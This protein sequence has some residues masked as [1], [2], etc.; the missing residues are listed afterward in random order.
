MRKD[1]RA[2]RPSAI[3]RRRWR[4]KRSVVVGA[5]IACLLFALALLV[6][7]GGD[8]TT[9]AL[10]VGKQQ[11]D[12]E[13]R[14]AGTAVP[15][16]TTTAT[17]PLPTSSPPSPAATHKPVQHF[18][19]PPQGEAPGGES[20]EENAGKEGYKENVRDPD[21]G[22]AD[23]DDDDPAV[24]QQEKRNGFDDNN[25]PGGI[26]Q[27]KET[28]H[29]PGE[30][31]V[32]PPD[33]DADSIEEATAPPR[34][35]PG[36]KESPAA[37]KNDRNRGPAAGP[38]G[39][40]HK[41]NT[42][43]DEED[44]VGNGGGGGGG[45]EGVGDSKPTAAPQDDEIETDVG[46]GE[47]DL[48][49]RKHFGRWAREG[50]ASSAVEDDDD[51]NLGR[52]SSSIFSKLFEVVTR[53]QIEVTRK[54]RVLPILTQPRAPLGRS[55]DWLP[56]VPLSEK[57][58]LTIAKEG[59]TANCIRNGM[60]MK[61]YAKNIVVR[62]NQFF[63]IRGETEAVA[64]AL[65]QPFQKLIKRV[66]VDTH[67]FRIL[68][69]RA[70]STLYMGDTHSVNFHQFHGYKG[71]FIRQVRKNMTGLPGGSPQCT[72]IVTK[73]TVFMYHYW[74]YNI[75]HMWVNNLSPFY[76]TVTAD[77]KRFISQYLRMSS[78]QT[79]QFAGVA[80]LVIVY[81]DDKPYKGK[82]SSPMLD[83]LLRYFST[84]PILHAS[85]IPEYTCFTNAI[86]GISS[87]EDSQIST[88][89]D[90]LPLVRMER[91]WS[92]YY[93]SRM[94][95]Q[96]AE[97]P[98]LMESWILLDEDER[99]D[100]APT[101]LEWTRRFV[102]MWS[103]LTPVPKIIYL[104]RNTEKNTRGRR[105]VN[106]EAI[107][108]VMQ[109]T[110]KK[111]LLACCAKAEGC[112]PGDIPDEPVQKIFLERMPFLE[113]V[114]IMTKVGVLIAPHGAGMATCVWMPPGAVTLEFVGPEGERL[115][116]MY[117]TMC[118][119]PS[120]ETFTRGT[121]HMW[122]LGEVDPEQQTVEYA[123]AHPDWNEMKHQRHN[124]VLPP[125]VLKKH[126]NLAFRQ[127]ERAYVGIP[128]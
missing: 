24:M 34:Q 8:D 35:G 67:R 106:E 53:E 51:E 1:H 45:G 110:A 16:P 21:R 121:Q 22:L 122:F 128:W 95:N 10:G 107:L 9:D 60:Q 61:C 108:P 80:D 113:Q 63:Y 126:M 93:R 125:E 38:I 18:T 73:P 87:T 78:D 14:A 120:E 99:R 43:G 112:V 72:H 29:R 77:F 64:G 12:A 70:P 44:E 20:N 2:S 31:Q 11:N 124:I 111:F 98:L 62:K 13:Q 118:H 104:S 32:D 40:A 81:V 86:M 28:R 55:F 56:R 100:L 103:T 48:A 92:H 52:L 127:Y 39:R 89:R 36:K 65:M 114:Y 76:R 97:V 69:K 54:R 7:R 4:V 88:V 91:D 66:R 5:A 42:A 79:A 84:V 96:S 123:L 82:F 119:R 115:P 58:W 75:Y 74:A 105:V 102:Q 41:D 117:D 19:L 109:Q 83:L 116:K 94:N 37:G 23:G 26:G 27:P 68:R 30:D 90:V 3:R 33:A 17:G 46:N 25:G 49:H 59:T 71:H 47:T 15:I 50:G 85:E 101:R 57:E 6:F